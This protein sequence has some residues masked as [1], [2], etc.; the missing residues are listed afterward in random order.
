[1]TSTT[2][3]TTTSTSTTSEVV[4]QDGPEERAPRIGREEA[5][6]LHT[7]IQESKEPSWI[8]C[9]RCHAPASRLWQDRVCVECAAAELP[10]RNRVLQLLGA[11]ERLSEVPFSPSYSRAV[12][13]ALA[14]VGGWPNPALPRFERPWAV[15]LLGPTGTGKSMLAVELYWRWYCRRFRRDDP[16]HVPSYGR[17][18]R[19][20]RIADTA[21]SEPDPRQR[22]ASLEGWAATGFLVLDELGIGHNGG[23]WD[24]I[25]DVACSRY[26]KGL[27]TVFNTNLDFGDGE[28]GSPGLISLSPQLADRMRSGFMVW[29]GGESLRGSGVRS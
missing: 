7:R 25:V 4:D 13:D 17:F 6:R 18:V 16:D 10:P 28:D 19:A 8:A 29:M 14:D 24:P 3:G 1:M 2:M 27:P 21:L 23:A 12:A 20:R 26:D 11:P 22:R 9:P 15:T 5:A